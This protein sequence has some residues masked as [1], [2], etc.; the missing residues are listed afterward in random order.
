MHC[1]STPLP[2]PD[3]GDFATTLWSAPWP[4]VVPRPSA[5]SPGGHIRS[6]AA[7]VGGGQ[8]APGRRGRRLPTP[9][10]GPR[11]HRNLR[12]SL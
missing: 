7:A 8:T 9:A 3:P 10:L 6:E 12:A 11:V 4:A 5:A 1:A 2:K